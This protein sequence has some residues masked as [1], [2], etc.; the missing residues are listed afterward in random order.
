MQQDQDD[1]QP[2]EP[3][4]PAGPVVFVLSAGASLGAVQVGMLQALVDRGIMPDLIL[5]S[6]VGA[7]NGAALAENPTASGIERM[8]HL[9]RTAA[10]RQLMPRGL[11]HTMA[12]ARRSE[13]VQANDRVYRFLQRSLSVTTFDQLKLPFQC[14]ATDVAL[15]AEAWFDRGPLL[16]AVLASSA[17]PAI[18]PSVEIDG[19][20]YL[21]GAIVN[22]VPIRRAVELGARTVYVLEVGLLSRTWREP[23]RP[24]GTAIQAYWIARRH[25]Y[26]QELAAVPADVRIHL[27]PDGAPE[28]QRFHDFGQTRA[29]IDGARTATAAYLD[30]LV[31]AAATA[32]A[33]GAGGVSRR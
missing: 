1:S 22:D 24:M 3:D 20:R 32:P 28:P 13:A 18:F 16:D 15:E 17:M 4:A 10:A 33:V 2:D 14:V 25:R 5:G 7:I 27:L 9:W 29:L 19:S 11:W 12:L 30:G 31:E 6:S 8:A 26:K 23:K 21:D